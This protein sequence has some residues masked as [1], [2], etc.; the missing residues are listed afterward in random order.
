MPIYYGVVKGHKV[1]VF[2]KKSVSFPSLAKSVRGL[3]KAVANYPDAVWKNFKTREEAE[4]YVKSH[5]PDEKKP[6]T[7]PASVRASNSTNKNRSANTAQKAA[8]APVPALAAKPVVP[9]PVAVAI[10][11]KDGQ[12]NSTLVYTPIKS[13]PAPCT[14][15]SI[16]SFLDSKPILLSK[17]KGQ[18]SMPPNFPPSRTRKTSKECFST[19]SRSRTGNSWHNTEMLF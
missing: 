9:P 3:D 19:N 17:L 10:P 8:V 2:R 16:G 5:K 7:A 12:I 6:A 18:I 4:N 15:P 13:K 14:E 1:G 11:E